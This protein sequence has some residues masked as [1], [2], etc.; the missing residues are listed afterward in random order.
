ME[1]RPN[2]TSMRNASVSLPILDLARTCSVPVSQPIRKSRMSVRRFTVLIIVQV[3]M[4]VHVVQWLVMGVT[5]APVEPS[6]AMETIKNGSITAGFIFFTVA[7][8]STAILG[9]WFC[10]WGCH[11]LLLQDWCSTLLRRINIRPKQFRSRLLRFIPV[12][13][14]SY[15][16]LW[17]AV[18]RF[19]I[20]PFLQPDLLP[21]S[22]SWKMTTTNYWSIFPGLM[23]AI[24]FL[25]VCGFL[26]VYF[27]GNK[28]YCTY[29]CPYGGFFAPLD[30]LAIGRIRVTDACEGCGHCTAVCTSNVRVHEEVANY[31][32]VVDPG[33]MKCG[34]C[35]TVCPKEAL[36]FGFGKPSI[37]VAKKP[38]EPSK[39]DLS[40]TGE[41]ALLATAL[42]GFYAVYFPF[43]ESAGKS[44]VPLLF[45]SGI[46]ACFAFMAWKSSQI[47]RRIPTGFH[48]INFVRNRRIAPAGVAWLAI[49][50]C[51]TLGLADSLSVNLYGWLAYRQDMVVQLSEEAVFTKDRTELAP[52][53]KVAAS[54]AIKLYQPTLSIGSGGLA[55]F[56]VR[57]EMVKL[58]LV[59]LH[60]V[61]DDLKESESILRAMWQRNPQE[62]VALLMGRV[63]RLQGRVQE[64]DAWFGSV[65]AENPEWF[66]STEEQMTWLMREGRDDD[67]IAIAR[68]VASDDG[69][70]SFAIR[71]L[72]MLLIQRGTVDEVQEGIRI[73]EVSLSKDP[74]NPFIVGA[75]ALGQIRLGRA[76]D[77][78]ELLT[79][80]IEIVPNEPTIF[81]R[82]AEAHSALGNEQEQQRAEQR[83]AEIRATPDHE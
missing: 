72:A 38:K 36:Y 79:Q 55:L 6:E 70:S 60:A 22:L 46:A 7:M 2:I 53:M 29:A 57:D 5:I 41:W 75:I 47:L 4:V 25:L 77:A 65:R 10:G 33:C 68:Q 42:F 11:I 17:P 49:T 32:M 40:W 52:Q 61:L 37:A 26:T 30:E 78:I 19:A 51:V 15:M 83:A 43:G 64:S 3:L 81:D 13:L 76:A 24:P 12:A 35:I 9:R 1:S 16:F 31:G 50:G 66:S 67:A 59:W 39:W 82:L 48:R 44:T 8:V 34:D 73:A 21:M 27:L 69:I 23:L 71:R 18:Y 14:A 80:F 45:A 20:A 74:N 58:R 63:I 28:G 54:E 62:I 56:P